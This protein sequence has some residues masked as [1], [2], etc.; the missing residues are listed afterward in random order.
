MLE[1]GE[2][3]K[4]RLLIGLSRSMHNVGYLDNDDEYDDEDER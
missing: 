4:S 3:T 1:I 2:D